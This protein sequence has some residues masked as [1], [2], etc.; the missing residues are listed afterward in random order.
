VL[1]IGFDENCRLIAGRPCSASFTVALRIHI[2][3]MEVEMSELNQQESRRGP[4]PS[5]S[6]KCFM[7]GLAIAAGIPRV[8][9]NHFVDLL[10][11]C[12]F[13]GTGLRFGEA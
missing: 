12:A 5:W 8:A 1:C 6:A 9:E 2:F 10:A 4:A 3:N 11:E 7:M 13:S